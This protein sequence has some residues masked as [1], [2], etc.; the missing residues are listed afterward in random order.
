MKWFGKK[1]DA[2][3]ERSK[4]LPS[5]SFSDYL[6]NVCKMAQCGKHCRK[7][8]KRCHVVHWNL[9]TLSTLGCSIWSKP[10]HRHTHKQTRC[11]PSQKS[12]GGSNDKKNERVVGQ[13]SEMKWEGKKCAAFSH[14]KQ[15]G[16]RRKNC[17]QFITES[18][19]KLG[20]LL[21]MIGWLVR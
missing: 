6:E 18:T 8:R 11:H 14:P 17:L 19:R 10:L 3:D 15:A 12:I 2:Q 13:Q 5:S 16:K 4:T 21:S 7:R 20:L 1:N 9:C